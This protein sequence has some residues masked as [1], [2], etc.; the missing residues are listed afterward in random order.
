MTIRVGAH[1][2]TLVDVLSRRADSQGGEIA[3]SFLHDDGTAVETISYAQLHRR[4]RAVAVAIRERSRPGARVLLLAP[5]GLGFVIGTYASMYAGTV[6]VPSATPSAVRPG[7]MVEQIRRLVA[8]AGISVA[9]VAN[10]SMARIITDAAPDLCDITWLALGDVNEDAASLWQGVQ[11]DPTGLALL[12]Y[13]S[14]ST[15]HPRGVMITHANL[16]AN[17]SS[18]QEMLFDDGPVEGL[19]WLP[20]YHD[21][22]LFGGV[23]MTVYNGHHVTLM[24]PAHFAQR[25]IRWLQM[26]SRHRVT[27][28][29]VPNFALDLCVRRTTPE[30]RASLN[31]RSLRMLMCGGEPIRAETFARFCTAF[32][33]AGYDPRS[34]SPAYGLAECT[35]MATTTSIGR[36]PMIAQFDAV[37]LR[38]GTACVPIDGKSGV[39][40]IGCGTAE[41]RSH[42]LIVDQDGRPV[43]P[44]TIGEI[45]LTGPGVTPGYWNQPETMEPLFREIQGRRYLC[46]GDLGFMRDNELFVVSRS[47]DLIKMHGQ[48][49]YPQDIEE[50]VEAADPALLP[51]GSVAFGIGN[52]GNEGLMVVAEVQTR[53]GVDYDGIVRALRSQIASR[54]NLPLRR[55]VL[56][57]KRAVPKTTSGK[58]RRHETR[59]MWLAGELRPLHVW[60]LSAPAAQRGQVAHAS[61]GSGRAIAAWLKREITRVTGEDADWTGGAVLLSQMGLSSV[62]IAELL[63]CAETQFGI[64]LPLSEIPRDISFDEMIGTIISAPQAGNGSASVSS[65]H[66]ASPLASFARLRARMQ[67]LAELGLHNPF[68][69]VHEGT[70][71]NTTHIGGRELLNFASYNY[72]GLSGHPAVNEAAKQAIDAMGTSVS[73]SRLVSG[74]RSLHREL[75]HELANLIGT[76]D[77]IVFVSG[78]LT[79]TTVLGHLAGPGDLIVHDALAHDSILQGAKLSGAVHRAFPHNDWRALDELLDAIGGQYASIFIAIEGVYSMDGDI[80]DLHRFIEVKKRHNAWLLVDEAHSI[81]VLGRQGRGIAEHAG[82]DASDVELWMGTLSKSLASCGGY[83]AGSGELIEVLKYTAPGFVF[84]VGLPPAGAAAALA[85]LRQLRREPERVRRLQARAAQFLELARAAGLNTG[86][87]GGSAIVPI[88]VGDSTSAI[89]C[90]ARLRELGINVQP[91]VYPAVEENAARLRFFLSCDH[92]PEQI[93]TAVAA[94]AA[95]FATLDGRR[96]AGASLPRCTVSA[97]LDS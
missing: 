50:T 92:T 31:L 12:Q 62:Q 53:A 45:C 4:V 88:I 47:K 13:T 61:N 15:R 2:K 17:L 21:M 23:F 63:S 43:L 14:G 24:S 19:M 26:I 33:A 82:I 95:T 27:H 91:V 37:K 9:I 79:N 58:V 77:A 28:S 96:Y 38:Q 10:A 66:P 3:Y 89:A 78:N 68:F 73:A 49:Y 70:A 56:V 97:T 64:S 80:P 36:P 65:R 8:D 83:I 85:A 69:T 84:S 34:F 72:L 20:P 16:M 74:E 5:P 44:G 7:R 35:V 59:R 86:S 75:E 94:V 51:Q 55:L 71:R 11:L 87:S 60:E 93:R 46:T 52:N 6:L 32:A 41:P 29:A 39:R 18:L 67:G 30:Q 57:R 42:I 48:N 81:G 22:G 25:P 40:L 76:E 90:A 54:H 1:D